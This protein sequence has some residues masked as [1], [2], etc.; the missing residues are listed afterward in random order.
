MTRLVGTA[1]WL[2]A[3]VQLCTGLQATLRAQHVPAA[4]IATPQ[5]AGFNQQTWDHNDEGVNADFQDLYWSVPSRN[6]L[7]AHG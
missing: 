1:I 6:R 5:M 3:A 7:P 4:R 2:L